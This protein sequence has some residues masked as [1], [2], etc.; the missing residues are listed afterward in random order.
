MPPTLVPSA[1][2]GSTVRRRCT[3]GRAG[4]ARAA[5]G[6]DVGEELLDHRLV[7]AGARPGDR[8][9]RRSRT[10]PRRSVWTV[11]PPAITGRRGRRRASARRSRRPLGRDLPLAGRAAAQA[12]AHRAPGDGTSVAACAQPLGRAT[13]QNAGQP[14]AAHPRAHA[15]PSYGSLF[16]ILRPPP[17]ERGAARYRRGRAGIASRPNGSPGSRAA[18]PQRTCRATLL[19]ALAQ[20]DPPDL[21][22]QRL[23]QVGHELDHA[24]V[25]VGREVVADERLD[26]LGQLVAT[27]RGRRPA[28]RTP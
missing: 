15:T 1:N 28:R 27:A 9:E 11:T 14:P 22:G 17:G 2:W 23:G 3:L 12:R 7:V 25:G 18:S 19:L 8:L 13:A 24:R 20:L 5:V 4:A 21:A 6:G 16:S 26:L 10:A